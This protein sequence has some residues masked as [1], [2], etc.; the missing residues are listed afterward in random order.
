MNEM[1]A[2]NFTITKQG[3]MYKISGYGKEQVL[4][5]NDLIPD[6]TGSYDEG[7]TVGEGFAKGTVT[8]ADGHESNDM[9]HGHVY[10]K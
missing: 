7:V 9:L 6:F 1:N 5:E 8:V 4:N 3:K 2:G 10:H